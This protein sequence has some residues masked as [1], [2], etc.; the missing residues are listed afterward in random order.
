MAAAPDLAAVAQLNLAVL[1]GHISPQLEELNS[2]ISAPLLDRLSSLPVQGQPGDVDS[3]SEC[4][5]ET[6]FAPPPR[7]ERRGEQCTSH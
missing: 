2:F 5:A 4:A 1:V 7:L 6:N 3:V